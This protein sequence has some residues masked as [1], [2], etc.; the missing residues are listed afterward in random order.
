MNFFVNNDFE[1]DLSDS[2]R[3]EMIVEAEKRSAEE[4][5][6]HAA[7]ST[8]FSNQ[9]SEILLR[10][11]SLDLFKFAGEMNVSAVD[12]A[13]GHG[14]DP[15]IMVDQTPPEARLSRREVNALYNEAEEVRV[16]GLISDEPSGRLVRFLN[17]LRVHI[18][19]ASALMAP[20]PTLV[21]LVM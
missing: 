21:S 13:N 5:A 7:T 20:N 2:D 19:D 8:N 12:P 4:V 9:V 15:S 3:T 6:K 18:R 10:V 16:A 14:D 17:L 11:G 1:S